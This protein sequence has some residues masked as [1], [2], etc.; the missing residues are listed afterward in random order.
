MMLR[1]SPDFATCYIFDTGQ[2]DPSCADGYSN[3]APL[4]VPVPPIKYAAS[5][6]VYKF[7][8]QTTLRLTAAPL[9]ARLPYK[10]C[11]ATKIGA[12]RCLVGVVDGFDWN[13]SA[14]DTLTASTRGLGKRTTFTWYV[15][16]KK[17]AARLA[18]TG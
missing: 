5:A 6:S 13:R 3:V 12:R 4:T 10:V 16:G 11:Y 18:R 15:N 9:G 14:N 1:A 17:V 7:I 8:R 2:Y